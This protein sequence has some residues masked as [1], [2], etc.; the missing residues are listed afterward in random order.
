M[1]KIYIMA[2][3]IF[4]FLGTSV[5]VN[6]EVNSYTSSEQILLSK[7]VSVDL[8]YELTENQKLEMVS[9]LDG[10]ERFNIMYND[11]SEVPNML[12]SAAGTQIDE[13]KLN[14]K[15]LLW[16]SYDESGNLSYIRVEV[17]YAWSTILSDNISDVL[18]ISWDNEDFRY[19]DNSHMHINFRTNYYGYDFWKE[20]SS[21]S[22]GTIG[23]NYVKWYTELSSGSYFSG[24]GTF[25][26]APRNQINQNGSIQFYGNYCHVHFQGTVSINIG[27]T[28]SISISGKNF[29]ELATSITITYY[30]VY[31]FLN[32]YS[33]NLLSSELLYRQ[34][35]T[36]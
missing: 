16:N 36:I 22:L 30:P 4:V 34:V 35:R 7:G 24:Y 17:L 10:N 8:L 27:A 23:T 5:G 12:L 26:V 13:N 25:K 3:L 31:N 2:L 15:I 28:G 1:K 29:S 11:T 18:T 6:A 20:S 19:V 9:N 33:A 32:Q 21:K 14:F